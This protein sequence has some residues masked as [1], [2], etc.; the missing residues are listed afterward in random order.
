M[1][2]SAVLTIIVNRKFLPSEYRPAVWREAILALR[3][4]FF[5]FFFT[6]FILTQAFGLKL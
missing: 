2:L 5:G 3:V 6:L 4:A 1:A